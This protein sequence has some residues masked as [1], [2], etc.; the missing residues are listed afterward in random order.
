M[1]AKKFGHL[2][3]VVIDIV[4]FLT[5]LHQEIGDIPV[6]AFKP[7]VAL[8]ELI[9]EDQTQDLLRRH[10]LWT[11]YCEIREKSPQIALKIPV[12]ERN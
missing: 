1:A 12:T 4:G 8:V 3:D 9:A 5:K 6:D 10:V 11:S 2:L 7:G